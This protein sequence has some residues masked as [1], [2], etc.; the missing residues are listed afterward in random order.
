MLTSDEWVLLSLFLMIVGFS[1]YLVYLGV[2]NE[3]RS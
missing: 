3:K 1:L 2:K